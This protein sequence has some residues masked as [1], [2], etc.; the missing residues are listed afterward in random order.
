MSND[1]AQ[2]LIFLESELSA[3]RAENDR[4]ARELTLAR[5]VIGSAQDPTPSLASLLRL[6]RAICAGDDVVFHIDRCETGDRL[7]H[8]S[9][10]TFCPRID[11]GKAVLSL[12]FE[13][14]NLTWM[15]RPD[16]VMRPDIV[17]AHAQTDLGPA[18]PIG[19]PGRLGLAHSGFKG[20]WERAPLGAGAY[21]LAIQI[22]GP[23]FSVRKSTGLI[24]HG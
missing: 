4:L 13:G 19:G 23:D 3:Y 11:S 24:L 22:D 6:P 7:L 17:A 14:T 21:V 12:L 10:W 20:L 16:L 8:I 2:R 15:A 5:R 18:L 1:P 9:G